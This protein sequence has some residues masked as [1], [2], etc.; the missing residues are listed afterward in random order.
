M[1]NE[2]MHEQEVLDGLVNLQIVA[3]LALVRQC[4]VDLVPA[5]ESL[6]QMS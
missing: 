1:Q 6:S 3:E 4:P 5:L 2:P